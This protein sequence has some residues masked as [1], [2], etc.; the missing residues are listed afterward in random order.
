M[1]V[2]IAPTAYKGTL[3]P[4]ESAQGIAQAVRQLFPHAEIDLCPIADGG[5]GWLEVWEFYAKG[6][7]ERVRVKVRDP[8]G[9]PLVAEWLLYQGRVAVIESARACGVKLLAEPSPFDASTEGV[10]DL[11]RSAVAHPQVGEIW[12]GLGGSATTD[13]GTGALRALGF[14]T[15]N[16][17]GEPIPSGGRGLLQLARIVHPPE[18]PLQGKRLTLCADVE[19]AIVGEHGS[20]RVYGPQK[21]A[22]PEQVE[23]LEQGLERFRQVASRERG[24]DLAQVIGSGSAGGMGGGLSAYLGAPIV[25]GVA[26]LL[27]QIGWNERLRSADLLITGEGQV[28]HQTLMGKGVGIIVQQAVSLGVPVWIIAGRKGEGWEPIARLPKVTVV[29]A[30]EVAPDRPP[31]SALYEAVVSFG[32]SS[33]T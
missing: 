11:I 3:T 2:L 27:K 30:S 28:D 4:I 1:R 9:R 18:D 26:W 16:E 7:T 14:Q 22:T 5:D 33:G 10:G 24:V 12:L 8:L 32:T 20:A 29:S 17:Q 25:S 23:L 31:A 19:N 13:G 15:L 21:G 6:D